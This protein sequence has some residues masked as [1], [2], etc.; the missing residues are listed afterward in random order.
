[1][2]FGNNGRT[3][4]ALAGGA[5]TISIFQMTADGSLA[6]QGAVSVPVGVVGLAAR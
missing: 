5:H 3:L 1:M 6:A 4:Y 2:V